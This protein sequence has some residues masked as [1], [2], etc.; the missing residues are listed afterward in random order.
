MSHELWRFSASHGVCGKA[1][2]RREWWAPFP[3]GATRPRAAIFMRGYPSRSRGAP[4]GSSPCTPEPS[5]G[6]REG[7]PLAYKPRCGPCEYARY[8]LRT[9]PCI[10]AHGELKKRQNSCDTTL[11]QSYRCCGKLGRTGNIIIGAM[12]V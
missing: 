2:P 9:T 6:V 11:V 7:E 10:D 1:R 3:R 5:A 12:H 4:F 8:S